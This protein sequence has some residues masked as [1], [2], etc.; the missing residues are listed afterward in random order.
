M[1]KQE[2]EGVAAQGSQVD[3]TKHT[4][5]K[6]QLC[7]LEPSQKGNTNGPIIALR[8]CLGACC[9]SIIS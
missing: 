8:C 6:P 9:L 5:G 1:T 4:D 7:S 3:F 2:K